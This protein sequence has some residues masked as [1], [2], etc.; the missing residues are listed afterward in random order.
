[1]VAGITQGNY[2]RQGVSS[3]L[4]AA[5][6]LLLVCGCPAQEPPLSPGAAAFKAEVNECLNKV[7]DKLVEPVT[8]R[9]VAQISKI[10]EQIEPETSRLCRMC[11]FNIGVLNAIGVTLAVHPPKKDAM[12]NFGD[13]EVVRQTL[14]NRRISTQRLFLQDGSE[15]YIICAPLLK[16]QQVK[17]IL[18]LA[19]SS[20]EAQNRWKITDQEFLALDFNR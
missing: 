4:L 15:I 10:L 13:F 2:F 7:S 19:L 12:G 18:A 17:G 14:K 3:R 20:E 8:K 16:E 5:L 11:P 1:M 6:V 9:D